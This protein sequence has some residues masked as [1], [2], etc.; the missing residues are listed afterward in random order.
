MRRFRVKGLHCASCKTRLEA[1]LAAVPGVHDARINLADASATL[2]M[3]GDATARDVKA[4]AARSGYGLEIDSEGRAGQ[5]E[6]EETARLARDTLVAAALVLPVFLI[7]M[8]GHAYAPAHHFVARTIGIQAS[9]TL[10]FLLVGA[11]LAGPGRRFL[12]SGVPSL[13]RGSP[14]MNALV[15]LGTSAA[16]GFS[17]V[18]TFLPGTIP[19]GARAVYFETAGAI[20]VLV[21]LGRFLEAR[22]KG[23]AGAAIQ[24]LAGLQPRTARIVTE[25]GEEDRPIA[26]LQPG[27]LVRVRPGERVPVDGIVAEGSS[28]VD[29]SMLT[30]EPLPAPKAGGDAVAGATVNGDGALLVR[31]TRVGRDTVLARIVQMVQDAQ[32]ARLPVEDLV[33]RVAA[34]FV[35]AVMLVAAVT[36][37]AWLAFAPE[38]A[39]VA[40][41]SVLIVACPCAMGLAVPTSIMTGTGRAAELGVLFRQGDALQRL[42]D[43]DAIAFDK[44]GTL[45]EGAPRLAHVEIADGFGLPEVLEDAAAVEALSGHPVARAVTKAVEGW[46]EAEGFRSM[47]GLG[48]MAAVGGRRVRVGS[49]RLMTEAGIDVSALADVAAERAR[50]G[51]TAFFVGIGDRP[52]AVLSV[53]DP[54]KDAAVDAIRDLTAAGHRVAMVSGDR[55]AAAEAIARQLGIGAVFAD[56]LPEAKVAVIRRLARS[57]TTAFV[58]DGINDAPALAAADVGI[59]I[60][61][62]ADVATEAA[63]VV[64]MSGDPRGVVTAIGVSRDTMRNV[65]QNLAWAF[66]YNILL[67]PVAA[68]ALHPAF[69]ILLSPTL[70]AAAMAL[71]S[72]AV[73]TN[74]LR[75]RRSGGKAMKWRDPA[76]AAAG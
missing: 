33:D 71:S 17:A 5:D 66:G 8:A 76:P 50:L 43:V 9:W 72:V 4:A 37:L 56:A 27:D 11:A 6:R 14:D 40:G 38:H 65:R 36:V 49:A 73:V 1:A 67:I 68:G 32:G 13:L 24:A 10:Q 46:P 23:K 16:F 3:D 22:A 54:V 59:A 7:E 64:L 75:L 18:A 60:G 53:A 35:P 29:E 12:E 19:A 48:V 28:L 58:G 47:P 74:A 31:A 34:R 52:A 44:T 70:A 45:T 55:R 42:G 30:G 69:G 62:G 51:E 15:A 25:G 41:V 63:D 2:S 26:R 21:L 20:V 39:L 57:G 61:T